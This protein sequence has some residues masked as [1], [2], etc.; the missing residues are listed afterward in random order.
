M[1]PVFFVQGFFMLFSRE[2]LWIDKE[3]ISLKKCTTLEFPLVALMPYCWKLEDKVGIFFFQLYFS[4]P[5]F[6]LMVPLVLYTYMKPSRS[7]LSI[8]MMKD[9]G[10]I[11]IAQS[12]LQDH[13]KL[14]DPLEF[15]F[16]SPGGSLRQYTAFMK[17][18]LALETPSNVTVCWHMSGDKVAPVGLLDAYTTLVSLTDH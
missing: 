17:W 6:T 14:T 11:P 10:I 16:Y 8:K 7:Q 4:W 18:D 15:I 5:R 9:T 3:A 13:V 1:H 2:T 12:P